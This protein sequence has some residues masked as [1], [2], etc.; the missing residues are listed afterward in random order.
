MANRERITADISLRSFLYLFAAIAV[1]GFI[2]FIGDILIL[3]FASIIFAAALDPSVKAL[4]KL[5]LPRLLAVVVIY[6]AFIGLVALTISLVIP[7]VSEQVATLS[8]N[9]PAYELRIKQSAIGKPSL[10]PIYNSV[11]SRLSSWSESSLSHVG[12]F[13]IGLFSGIAGVLT[14]LVLTF[15]MLAGGKKMTLAAFDFIPKPVMRKRLMNLGLAIS[16]KLGYWLRGQAVLGFLIFAM[17]Y[18]GLTVLGIDYALTLAIIAG[19]M[20]MV[21]LVGAYLGAIPAVLVALAV[22]PGKAVSVA[23]FFLVIQQLEGHVFVPQVM[24][25][26]LGVPPVIILPAVLIGGRLFGFMGV[27]LAAP[28]TAAILVVAEDF[29]RQPDLNKV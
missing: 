7:A 13:A 18:V 15:Y 5:K 2:W 26:A 24:K 27:L 1:V 21:P 16:T 20:E 23:L 10:A 12:T 19:L 14:F 6:L 17:S 25:R 29:M 9:L 28:V 8:K 4:Q 11:A 22:S 3:V